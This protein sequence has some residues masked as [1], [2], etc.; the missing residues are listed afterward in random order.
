MDIIYLTGIVLFAGI[1]LLIIKGCSH[2]G[3]EL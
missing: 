1:T 2:S 3:G